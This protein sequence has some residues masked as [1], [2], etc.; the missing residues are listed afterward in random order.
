MHWAWRHEVAHIIPLHYTN[1]VPKTQNIS[2]PSWDYMSGM[3]RCTEKN[4]HFDWSHRLSLAWFHPF[5]KGLNP[6]KVE[7]S[8]P[9]LEER[10]PEMY[11]MLW[12]RRT[13]WTFLDLFFPRFFLG[14]VV[15]D[16]EGSTWRYC[17]PQFLFGFWIQLYNPKLSKSFVLVRLKSAEIMEYPHL[18]TCGECRIPT[19]RSDRER[20]IKNPSRWNKNSSIPP[21]C[22]VFLFSAM[23][24]EQLMVQKSCITRDV[25][26]YPGKT[27]GY[28]PYQLVI[29][30]FLPSTRWLSCSGRWD[31][32]AAS[33]YC[34]GIQGVLAE[35]VANS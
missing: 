25:Y 8:H 14:G 31:G 27:W 16:L 24:Q 12:R 30:G 1:F 4:T 6:V 3:Q 11:G 10:C 17:Q 2:R 35:Q 5:W 26:E 22:D 34:L 28:S 33:A 18:R 9:L 23:N 7:R 15:L 21:S 13:R 32:R 29:A 19:N 20:S